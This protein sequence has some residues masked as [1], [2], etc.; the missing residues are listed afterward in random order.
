VTRIKI[1]GVTTVEQALACTAAGADSIGVNFIP[2]SPRR[3][4]EAGGRAIVDAVGSRALVVGI[5]AGLD[6]DAMRAL[7]ARTGV[8]CLQLHGDE[9]P[10]DVEALLPHA[11]KAVRVA[12]ADDVARAEAMP[13][14]YVLA[15]AKVG[16]ALGGTGH[17]FDWSLVVRLAARRRLV[18]AGG[19]TPDN[20]GEAIAR[21]HP[22]CVDVAS[23]VESAPGIKDL[24][25]VHAFVQAVRRET[26]AGAD[27]P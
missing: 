24:A 20:V 5:V 6:V 15:D 19:L 17:T 22:W 2:T 26:P 11:Y 4:D 21:V 18:L 1:C 23:G 10:S 9:S 3:V 13:G 25:R 16:S 27:S 8:G 14:D 12:S 7:R